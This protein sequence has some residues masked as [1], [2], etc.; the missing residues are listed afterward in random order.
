M[1]D[2]QAKAAEVE[3]L[4]EELKAVNENANRLNAKVEQFKNKVFNAKTNGLTEYKGT[5]EYQMAFS[6][7]T[8][9]FLAK[10]KIKMR[11][12]P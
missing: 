4:K 2:A 9:I 5:N 6:Y 8:V 7:V 12:T 1:A 10:E 3:K 11:R